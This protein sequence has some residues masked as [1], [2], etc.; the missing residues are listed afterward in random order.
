MKPSVC[1]A[2]LGARRSYAVPI[3]LSRHGCLAKLFTDFYLGNKPLMLRAANL[4]N[5]SSAA[6]Q[7]IIHRNAAE[8]DSKFVHSFDWMGLHYALSLRLGRQSRNGLYSDI[9]ARFGRNVA[10]VGL[11]DAEVVYGFNGAA[12]EI[13]ESAKAQG[14]NTV[15]DQTIVP[16]LLIADIVRQEEKS[17][18]G[19]Q[20][21]GTNNTEADEAMHQRDQAE[22]AVADRIFCGSQFLADTIVAAGADHSRCRVIQYGVTPNSGHRRAKAPAF[23]S[24]PLKVL[25]AGQVGLRKGA[26]YLL[27]ALAQL[28]PTKVT[29]IF[30][31]EVKLKPDAT[32]PF[33]DV[34]Q[35]L[36]RV[37]RDRLTDLYAWADVF[38]LPSLCEGSAMVT[39]EAHAHGLPQIW[40]DSTGAMLRDGKDGIRVPERDVGALVE[41]LVR[42]REPSG[43]NLDPEPLTVPSLDTYGTSLLEN[44]DF[45]K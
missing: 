9:G 45:Q 16:P 6:A 25:F 34:A 33:D 21:V 30:A 19:W 7:K 39:H 43:Y 5:N 2:Q 24:G 36:G 28:G 12:K 3:A 32:R 23:Q 17:W 10:R 11:G 44:M 31:G 38:V 40:T 4:L 18:P 42:I 37:P 22:W 14:K 8:I 35:F 29:A 41:A 27:E 20:D 15:L 13:L 1:V 26:P